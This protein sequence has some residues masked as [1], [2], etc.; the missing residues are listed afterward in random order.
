MLKAGS[1]AAKIAMITIT[2]R[3]SIKVNRVEVLFSLALLL[4]GVKKYAQQSV[5]L[6]VIYLLK[7]IFQIVRKDSRAFLFIT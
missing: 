4:L 7:K 2:T 3:S 6:L 1:I 5:K